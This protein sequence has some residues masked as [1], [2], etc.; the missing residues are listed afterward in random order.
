MFQQSTGALA[1]GLSE[2]AVL[3]ARSVEIETLSTIMRAFCRGAFVA[4]MPAMRKRFSM[5]LGTSRHITSFLPVYCFSISEL[6]THFPRMRAMETVDEAE[7]RWSGE[8]DSA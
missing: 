3:L 8:H 2:N 1:C 5:I 7:E 6:R 4:F